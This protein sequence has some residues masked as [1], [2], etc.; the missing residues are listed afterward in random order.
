MPTVSIRCVVTAASVAIHRQG[1]LGLS[2][3]RWWGC[4]STALQVPTSRRSAT[5]RR[6]ASTAGVRGTALSHVCFPCVRWVR[7]VLRVPSADALHHGC[8]GPQSH[9]ETPGRWSP[10]FRRLR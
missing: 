9:A 8:G 2:H 7:R 5:T 10:S 4:A 1:R 6:G 3:R